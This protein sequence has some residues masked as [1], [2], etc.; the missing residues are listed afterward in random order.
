MN[1]FLIQKIVVAT[2]FSNASNRAYKVAHELAAQS[3][4]E[5]ISVFVK[6]VDDLALAMR[7]NIPLRRTEMPRLMEKVN[8]VIESRFQ[9]LLAGLTVVHGTRFVI[10]IGEPAEQV[11][12]VAKKE[13]ADLI[14]TGTR[15]RSLVSSLLL[16]STA[17]TLIVKSPCPVLTVN[18]HL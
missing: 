2:D 13:K 17:R 18:D 11:M 12:K 10:Q 16:G 6:D 7:Q 3:H 5:V 8:R 1:T 15:S 4:A 14:V 9:S